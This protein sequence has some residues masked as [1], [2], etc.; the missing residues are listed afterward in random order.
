M[1]SDQLLPAVTVICVIGFRLPGKTEPVKPAAV[2][3]K[4]E[5]TD[6]KL[7]GLMPPGMLLIGLIAHNESLYPW[8]G[9]NELLK[10]FFIEVPPTELERTLTTR[11][12]LALPLKLLT[13]GVEEKVL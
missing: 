4:T 8:P 10:E 2:Y 11:L 12:L 9:I 13:G 5:I 1:N 6:G 3:E 7:F